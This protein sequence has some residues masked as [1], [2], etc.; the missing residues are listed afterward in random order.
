MTGMSRSSKERRRTMKSV[1]YG[2]TGNGWSTV[3]TAARMDDA[4][5]NMFRAVARGLGGSF[6]DRKWVFGKTAEEV[7]AAFTAAGFAE[8]EG[9]HEART[10][11]EKWA[12]EGLWAVARMDPDRAREENGV[13][14]SK[15]D[16]VF[17][18]DLA[19]KAQGSMTQ[20][21]WDAAIRLANKYRRQIGEAP[22]PLA[23]R[24]S[25]KKEVKPENAAQ[26]F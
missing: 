2:T 17:G 10:P 20:K 1:R 5:F 11:N 6:R 13:G 26:P 15:F 24:E 23:K 16:G 19:E 8:S 7:R 25:K 4:E 9:P 18:H 21:Q 22:E 3:E 14:F 12:A